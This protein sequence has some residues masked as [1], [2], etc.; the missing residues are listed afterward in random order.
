MLTRLAA[1]P[2]PVQTLRPPPRS[3]GVDRVCDHLRAHVEESI[4]LD[5]LASVAAVSKFYLLR[6]FRRTHGVTPH[7]YQ[8]Q[9]R[10]A[11][12]WRF[13]VQGRSLSATA[14]DTGFA[15]Q[16]HLTRRFASAFG[17]TPARYARELVLSPSI[18]RGTSSAVRATAPQSAA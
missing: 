16:S 9:L 5:E 10:L 1:H 14:Y 3:A 12:A 4:S 15:D 7:A 17:V 11:H 2:L 6:T 18:A 8:M 13:I